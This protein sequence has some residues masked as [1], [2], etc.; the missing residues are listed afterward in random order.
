MSGLSKRTTHSQGSSAGSGGL[1]WQRDP[2]WEAMNAEAPTHK[3]TNPGF[4]GAIA[5]SKSIKTS[6]QGRL[7]AVGNKANC[8]CTHF[9]V[10]EVRAN[11]ALC[12]WPAEPAQATLHLR[13]GTWQSCL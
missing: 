11:S 10:Q 13:Q 6:L 9:P 7:E 5:M 2:E 12:F 8:C 3:I 1:H 4:A